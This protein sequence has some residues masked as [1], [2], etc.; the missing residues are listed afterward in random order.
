MKMTRRY[1]LKSAG[2]LS[3]YCGLSPILADIEDV[4]VT[5]N[6]TLVVIFLRGGMDGLNFIVPYN[7]PHYYQLRNSLAIPKSGENAALDLDGFFGL[8][9]KAA[10]LAPFFAEGSAVALHAVGYSQNTRSHFEEQDV[11]E[12]GVIGNT[13]NSDGWLNRHLLTSEGHGPI[14]AISIG[15]NLP[16]ILRGKAPAYSIRGLDNLAIPKELQESQMMAALESAYSS[17]TDKNNAAYQLSQAGKETLD[18]IEILQKV[19]NNPYNPKVTYP[20]TPLG[21]KLQQTAQLIK[22]NIG[23]EVVEIDYGGWDTHRQQ[24]GVNGRYA[25]MVQNLSQSISSFAKDLQSKLD[26]VLVITI[27][28]FGRTARENGT[29]GTD[30]G[31]ANCMFVMGGGVKKQKKPII[32]NWPGLAPEQLYQGR[33]LKHTIDFRDVLAEV[34]GTHLGNNNLQ[35]ILPQHQFKKVDF[36]N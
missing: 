35:K 10:S 20:N 11:W 16:R 32:A 25:N 15:D 9:P 18:S 17:P 26:D 24:G 22:A 5:R 6:K 19:A 31:W 3:L 14:R 28:D 13:V 1:F 23:I 30:H 36:L 21:K 29:R 12:T 2:L 7:D 34:V 27:S 8:H 33:D 4:K